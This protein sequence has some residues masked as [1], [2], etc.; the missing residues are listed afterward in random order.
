MRLF[1]GKVNSRALIVLRMSVYG[2]L[3]SILGAFM[4]SLGFI[5]NTFFND[6]NWE[7]YLELIVPTALMGGGIGFFYGFA[8]STLLGLAIASLTFVFFRE[9]RHPWLFRVVAGILTA[10][11]I[12]MI[13]PLDVVR[14]SLATILNNDISHYPESVAVSVLYVLAIYLSQIVARKYIQEVSP[15]GR[16]A[17]VR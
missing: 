10:V 1:Q 12:Y 15:N 7:E 14:W 11:G 5:E 13:S 3:T 16:K 8:A 2:T 6:A 9:T 4:F 17:K